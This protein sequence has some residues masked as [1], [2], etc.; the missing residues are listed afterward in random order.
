MRDTSVLF[1]EI[2]TQRHTCFHLT[3]ANET[4]C[5]VQY[6][7]T[8]TARHDSPLRNIQKSCLNIKSKFLRSFLAGTWVFWILRGVQKVKRVSVK[9]FPCLQYLRGPSPNCTT[10]PITIVT[11]FPTSPYL[12]LLQTRVDLLDVL[13]T[14]GSLGTSCSH[15]LEAFFPSA[16]QLPPSP[17]PNVCSHGSS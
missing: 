11:S 15:K 16:P 3:I 10:S 14:H 7:G 9:W 4:A 12:T 8:T 13:L 5:V 2:L 6:R 1:D 17:L